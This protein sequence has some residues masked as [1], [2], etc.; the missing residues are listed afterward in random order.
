[1]YNNIIRIIS[2]T[3]SANLAESKDCFKRV[4]PDN[5]VCFV[6]LLF[7]TAYI[8][9]FLIFYPSIFRLLT[10]YPKSFVF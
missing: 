5:Q 1:M 7:L 2:H 4:V 10:T 3:I 8:K 6:F 9:D